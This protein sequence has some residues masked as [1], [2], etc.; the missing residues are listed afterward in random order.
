MFIKTKQNNEDNRWSIL[1][2]FIPFLIKS[3]NTELLRSYHG[4]RAGQVLCDVLWSAKLQSEQSF[5]S[6]LV[7]SS[8]RFEVGSAELHLLERQ[9]ELSIRVHRLQNYLSTSFQTSMK[10]LSNKDE[11]AN[12]I[13]L[14]ICRLGFSKISW[15]YLGFSRRWAKNLCREW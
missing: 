9:F 2:L 5:L 12:K 6:N 10:C 14:I 15:S 11:V 1:S 3:L 13:N 7:Q 4:F 8:N